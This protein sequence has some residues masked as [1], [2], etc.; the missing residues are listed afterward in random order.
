MQIMRIGALQPPDTQRSQWARQLIGSALERGLAPAIVPTHKIES[1]TATLPP[2]YIAQIQSMA[3]ASDQAVS[4][5]SAGL[6]EAALR[7]APAEPAEQKVIGPIPAM[8]GAERVR[9]I[10]HSLL[11]ASSEEA[12]QGKVVFAEAGT[13]TG[14]GRMIAS[15]A[16][17]AAGAGDTVVISAP[18]TVTWQ[19][20]EDLAG[21]EETQSAG[22]SL[23][24]GRPNFVAPMLALEWATDNEC[25]PLIDWIVKDKGKPLSERAVKASAIV[26]QS[27]CWLLEDALSLAEDMPVTMVSLDNQGDTEDR[28]DCPAEALY[29]SLRQNL[30]KSAITLCSHYMLASH[31]RNVQLRRIDADCQDDIT[32]SLPVV[33]DLL[34]VDEAHLLEAAFAAIHSQTIHLRS[35]QRLVTAHV[36]TKKKPLLAALDSLGRYI[37]QT[38]IRSGNKP[39]LLSTFDDADTYLGAVDLALSALSFKGLAGHVAMTLRM[40]HNAIRNALDGRSTLRFD[41][42]PVRN[43]PQ[44]TVGRANLESPFARLWDGVR[45]AVLVSATLYSDGNS[46]R[47]ARW[48]MAVPNERA[49][50]LPPV[51]PEWTFS[52]VTLYT[53]RAE[54]VPDDSDEWAQACAEAIMHVAQKAVGGTLALCTSYHNAEQLVCYLQGQLGARLIVQKRDASASVCMLQY[55]ALHAAGI[56]PVWLGLGAAWTGIDLTDHGVS[57]G[58][59]TLLTDLIITRLP[60][61]VNRTLTHERR[62]AI[63]GFGIVWQEAVWHFRQGL[64]RLVRREGV[65]SRHLWVLDSRL[66]S[67]RPWLKGF[68]TVLARYS[69]QSER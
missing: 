64:G 55:R 7:G 2:G 68:K 15:L 19:L 34:I 16:A 54:P 53:L 29:Q 69:S 48:K 66:D 37:T 25:Q 24:L 18:L 31:I 3:Q 52:P 12:R 27:L 42:S 58:D 17:H 61:G 30:R 43:Y 49:V 39:G 47:L 59:D 51:H 11:T 21:I 60:L 62:V 50:Y 22:V 5:I 8:A 41:A 26:G 13:G 10:L 6:I 35:I 14:K 23:V 28:R 67:K 38:G 45:G 4:I 32:S 44:M 36:R 33:M 65:G 56:K 20:L 40:T 63:S 9:P 1:F 57:A 46:A